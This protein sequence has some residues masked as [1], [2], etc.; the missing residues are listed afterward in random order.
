MEMAGFDRINFRIGKGELPRFTELVRRVRERAGYDVPLAAIA[1]ALMGLRR[2]EAV[3]PEDRAFLGGE[4][5]EA[6]IHAAPRA[7]KR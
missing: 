1:K 6:E 2:V 5:T 7:R 3:R 4:Q